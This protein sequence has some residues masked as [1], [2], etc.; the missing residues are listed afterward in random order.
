MARQGG[1]DHGNQVM[2]AQRSVQKTGRRQDSASNDQGYNRFSG[3]RGE[4]MSNSQATVSASC[5]NRCALAVLAALLALISQP[6]SAQT[7]KKVS[8]PFSPIGLSSL[9]LFVAK[10]ARLYEKNNIEVDVIFVGASSALFQSM[11]SGA[12][13]LAGSGGPAVI[14]NVLKGGDII[15]VAATLPRFTQSIVVKPE[16]K[17]PADLAGKKIGVSR[18]GTV[19][20]FALQSALDAYSIKNVSILQ[21]GG[22][23]EEVTALVR[24]VI[25][26]AVIS[27]PYNFQLK[28]QGF[29]EVVSTSDLE[30][31]GAEFITNGIAA[32]KS[33]IE[34]D[35]EPL[36]RL[37]RSVAEAT[38]IIITDR[39]YS[40]KV[41]NKWMPV[42]DQQLLDEIAG[43]AADSF[44]RE[45][46]VPEGAIRDIVKQMAQSNL[47]DPK[48]A[49]ATPLTA[50]YDNRYV[51]EVKRSGFFAQLWK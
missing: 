19:T 14:A 22:Q 28:R 32:R 34:K 31:S 49:A 44:A 38:K 42:K 46:F 2:G 7:N 37:I 41:I 21:M 8:L 36:L 39:E 47:I 16:I 4:G 12:A 45:P 26:G 3:T 17:K 9:P 51:D 11:L 35:K 24:G 18:L 13:D 23:P 48:A 25:D 10:E 29:N 33:A 6:S 1:D 50:Y 43:F 27:P 5:R 30:K 40:K 20:H 15:Q